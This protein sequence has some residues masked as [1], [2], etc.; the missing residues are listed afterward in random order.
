MASQI[1]GLLQFIQNAMSPGASGGVGGPGYGSANQ[2][3][4]GMPQIPGMGRQGQSFGGLTAGMGSHAMGGPAFG[5]GTMPNIPGL[6]ELLNNRSWKQE[7]RET[8]TDVGQS[9]GLENALGG[10]KPLANSDMQN[11]TPTEEVYPR[12]QKENPSAD[13]APDKPQPTQQ[14]SGLSPFKQAFKKARAEGQLQFRF[15]GK[16]YTT[17][18][19]EET[20]DQW[21]RNLGLPVGVQSESAEMR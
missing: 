3:Q 16:K 14:E 2:G 12:K 17:R 1:Q 19:K 20:Q 9:R 6:Q 8:N 21:M 18:Y 10:G 7:L 4:A 15:N 13:V 11:P 5:K